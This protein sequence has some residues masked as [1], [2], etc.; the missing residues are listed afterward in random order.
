MN[1]AATNLTNAEQA[2]SATV[3]AAA[4]INSLSLM[5]YLSAI[6]G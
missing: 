5:D 6:N 3:Q 1:V 2:R 4:S